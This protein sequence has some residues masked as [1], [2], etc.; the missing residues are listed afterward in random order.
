MKMKML[1]GIFDFRTANEILKS[2]FGPSPALEFNN[3]LE[4]SAEE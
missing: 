3:L 2:Q 1:W 4:H